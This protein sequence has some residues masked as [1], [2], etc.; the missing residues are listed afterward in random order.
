MNGVFISYRREDS[1]PYAGRLSDLLKTHLGD[2]VVF[3]DVDGQPIA[4]FLPELDPHCP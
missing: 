3:M 1:Q 4:A 2:S